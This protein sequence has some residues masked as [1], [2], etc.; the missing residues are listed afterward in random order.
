MLCKNPQ[1]LQLNYLF[2]F[3]EGVSPASGRF[4]IESEVE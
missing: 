2:F 1:K 3:F 4:S